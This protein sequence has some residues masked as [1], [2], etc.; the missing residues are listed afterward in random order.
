MEKFRKFKPLVIVVC[1]VVVLGL[2]LGLSRF[3]VGK[4]YSSEQY[5][6]DRE[7]E[8]VSKQKMVDVEETTVEETSELSLE[9]L[10]PHYVSEEE[11]LE[12]MQEYENSYEETTSEPNEE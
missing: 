12:E 5:V 9:H 4:S 8:R 2:I 10:E 3:I 11:F 6:V 7:N 1:I